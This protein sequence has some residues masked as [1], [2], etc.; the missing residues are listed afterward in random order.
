MYLTLPLPVQKKWNHT[1]F[2]IPWDLKK[3][4]IKVL[5]PFVQTVQS[6]DKS[7]SQVPIEI[8]RDA[9]FKDLRALL[10][11]WLEAIPE[12][13]C[14]SSFPLNPKFMSHIAS[15]VRDLQQS[16]LQEPG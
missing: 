8:N 15:D 12:N 2:Y 5:R 6:A 16:F 13:V 9:S 7:I 11:R 3:P 4:H 10:G 1:I 14:F